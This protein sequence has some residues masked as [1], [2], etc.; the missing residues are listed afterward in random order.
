MLE[1]HL[2]LSRKNE[3]K[4]VWR[5][6]SLPM[7]H[8]QNLF[9]HYFCCEALIEKLLPELQNGKFKKLFKKINLEEV[10]KINQVHDDTE[11]IGSDIDTH[12]KNN[13]TQYQLKF[14]NR[15]NEIAKIALFFRYKEEMGNSYLHLMEK[16]E[17]KE[18]IESQFVSL[19]DKI[20]GYGLETIHEVLS[21]N[22]PFI[23]DGVHERYPQYLRKLENKLN[24]LNKFLKSNDPLNLTSI[25]ILSQSYNELFEIKL[26]NKRRK[27]TAKSIIKPTG[28]IIY[29]YCVK[30]LLEKNEEMAIKI[31]T[32]T[33]RFPEPV[34]K[35]G[36][37]YNRVYIK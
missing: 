36:I 20:I 35:N 11:I 37:D 1:T 7:H 23:D 3:L 22:V 33:D 26:K 15:I 13:M 19:T 9:M 5:F 24:H 8:R 6:G 29:D 30:A 16:A 32:Q 4:E 12:T 31:L 18:C 10:K 34:T 28:I 27:H 21:I 14:H 2:P 25:E 17:K